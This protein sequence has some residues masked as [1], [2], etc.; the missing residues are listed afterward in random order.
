MTKEEIK[1]S[2]PDVYSEIL[3]E[4]IA[5]ERKE[6]QSRIENELESNEAFDFKL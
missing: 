5:Q 3:Q 1:Q 6:S 2:Y 4:G